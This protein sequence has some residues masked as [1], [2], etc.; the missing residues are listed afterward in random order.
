MADG[1]VGTGYRIHTYHVWPV[2]A[3]AVPEPALALQLLA[4]GA[5]LAGAGPLLRRARRDRA[6]TSPE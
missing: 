4:G 1:F 5:V 6:P 2:R 3:R